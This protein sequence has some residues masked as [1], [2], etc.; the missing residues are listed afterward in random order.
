MVL[1]SSWQATGQQ[2]MIGAVNLN[3][4]DLTTYIVYSGSALHLVSIASDDSIRS[5]YFLAKMMPNP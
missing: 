1:D 2:A 4:V 5:L 3:C